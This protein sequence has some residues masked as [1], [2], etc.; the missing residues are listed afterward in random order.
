MRPNP[1]P[2][3]RN[4]TEVKIGRMPRFLQANIVHH[5]GGVSQSSPIITNGSGYRLSLVSAK[6]WFAAGS[7]RCL[8]P[9]M[10]VS[11]SQAG[12]QSVIRPRPLQRKMK[13]RTAIAIVLDV[14]IV[15][16]VVSRS[17]QAPD[18]EPLQEL[19]LICI[20]LLDLAWGHGGLDI[21]LSDPVVRPGVN[22]HVLILGGT[23]G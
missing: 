2:G 23:A 1:Y 3:L 16:D 22:E 14:D 18:K 19:R 21:G 17:H 13:H 12:W 5:A 10:T 4:D 20:S 8:K 6:S 7:L 9:G 11:L 15:R